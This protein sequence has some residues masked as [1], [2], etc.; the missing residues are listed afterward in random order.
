[1]SK[2]LVAGASGVNGLAVTRYFKDQEN[3]TVLTLARSESPPVENVTHVACDLSDASTLADKFSGVTHL[4]Y[5]ALDP[6]DDAKVEADTNGEMLTNLLDALEDQ[7]DLQHVVFLQGGKVYGA[8]LG[9]YKTPALETDSRHF[10]PNLYFTQED[11]LKSRSDQSYQWTALRPD[12]VIGPSIGS[13]MN[14][15][16]LIAVYGTLCAETNTAMQ[17]PGTAAAY[18]VLVNVTDSDIVAKA[19]H[20]AFENDKAG[21]YNITNGDVFRWKH[22]WPEIANWFGL[23]IGEPQPISL[24]DRIEANA[25][26]WADLARREGLQEGDP[27]RLGPGAFGD[28]IFHVETDAIFDVNKARADGFHEMN[29]RSVESIISHLEHLVEQKLIS[30]PRR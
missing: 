30:K 5:A 1:M 20:W 29:R 26:V 9:V 13:A 25:D 18:E 10:P 16:N 11:I 3:W 22:V 4:F 19:T 8:H 6:H 2:L 12:I 21:A 17:F 15:A 27:D 24:E 23:E 7:T 14:L 28:F